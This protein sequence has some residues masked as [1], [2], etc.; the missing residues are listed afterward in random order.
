MY[1]LDTNI[2]SEMRRK[3]PHG[4][5]KAWLEA[6][7]DSDLHLSAV[8]LGEIQA[9]IELTRESDPGRAE[10]L[11]RW[12]DAVA[13][14]FNILPM[15]ATAFRLWARLLHRKPDSLYE[16]AMIAATAMIHGL[17]VV[18]RNVKDFAIFEVT[19]LNPFA[20]RTER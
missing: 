20:A 5:V 18:T 12:A 16:D 1:L 4:G 2:V 10:E 7:D 19:L 8:T 14:T 11:Q 6:T 17:T 15:D 13:V 3:K 9:G